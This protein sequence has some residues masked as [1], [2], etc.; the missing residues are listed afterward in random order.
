M[1]TIKVPGTPIAKARPKFFRKGNHVG[2]YNPQETKESRFL[3]EVSQQL[4]RG[5][6]PFTCPLQ[7]SVYFVMPIPKGLSKKQREQ[8]NCE[9]KHTKKPDVSNML[10]FVEDC[11]NGVAWKDDSQIVSIHAHKCYGESPHTEISICNYDE[12]EL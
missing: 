7:V 5:F 4:K 11:L 10:K 12:E 2:T 1:I 3:W 8:I 9:I 6:K